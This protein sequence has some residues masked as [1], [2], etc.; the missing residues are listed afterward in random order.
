[1]DALPDDF[2]A[3][4]GRYQFFAGHADYMLGLLLAQ[5]EDAPNPI[6][7]SGYGRAWS[8]SLTKTTMD[9]KTYSS[10]TSRCTSA[11]TY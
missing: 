5:F 9:C 3:A 7:L 8:D 11:A 1:M 2:A 4:L 10:A 6:G